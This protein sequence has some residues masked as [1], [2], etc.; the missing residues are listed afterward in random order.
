MNG[1]DLDEL[2]RF[3]V[4][5]A[6]LAPWEWDITT[7]RVYLSPQWR[8]L[9]GEQDA[10]RDWLMDELLARIHPDDVEG[11]KIRMEE[12]L[13]GFKSRYMAEFR[14]RSGRG[15]W[16]WTEGLGVV[17]Q[18][19]ADGTALRMVGTNSDIS[20]RRRA[21]E[22][23]VT[24]RQAAED[25]NR[26]KGDLLANV[27]H[28][29]RTP[30]N[31]IIGLN[32]LLLQSPMNDEQKN[33][34]HLI[35]SSAVSLLML[36]NDV[37]DF[38]KIEAGKLLFENVRF[39]VRRWAQEAVAPHAVAAEK[40]GL[41]VK[42][43]IADELPRTLVGDPGR[44]RQIVSNLMANAVKFTQRGGISVSLRPSPDQD[45]VG[46]EKLRLLMEVRDS[47]I[48][49]PK[50]KQSAIF[51]AFTQAD[52]S[53]TRQYGG[54][55]L[56]LAICAKLVALMGGGISVASEPGKG[57]AFRVSVVLSQV[58]DNDGPHTVPMTA[59]DM[60][61][62]GLKILLAEDNAVNELL[63]RRM[64]GQMGC[65]VD[66]AHDGEEALQMWRQGHYDLA[67]MDVQMPKLSGFD[68]TAHIRKMEQRTGAHLPIV[69]L[70][71]HAMVGDREKCLAAGMDAYVS[72]PVSAEMLTQAMRDALR[73][74]AA[75]SER[76]Q[77][78][79]T[80]VDMSASGRF[81]L[82]LPSPAPTS[83]AA[84]L[85]ARLQTAV[86]A[87]DGDSI[88]VSLLE[89]RPLLQAQGLDTALTLAGSLEYAARQERWA[90]LERALPLFMKEAERPNSSS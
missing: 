1:P 61:L 65:D 8:N 25:S 85:L 51:E 12:V 24:A 19:D 66:V 72:K 9:I 52:A 50:E 59:E 57:S 34:L 80:D 2:Q 36:L 48:G 45:D 81:T 7:Q 75:T 87:H 53:T 40:K 68:A 20:T 11:V 73:T 83:P 18:R 71:A 90:L 54:T 28:E 39:D 58:D 42:L 26:A 29:L 76:P 88:L 79:L 21:Q 16:L 43:N 38:S 77:E 70:T 4:E 82:P 62:T 84:R 3:A 10:G 32:K 55:G 63:M 67:L 13:L 44:L 89:L 60:P 46:T 27:S 35:D 5:A 17:T 14:I 22:A 64:L 74:A 56:G 86:A 78:M 23:L 31:A 69:A 37:L 33:F 6:G 15:D 47:G 41:Q 49:I 30:L